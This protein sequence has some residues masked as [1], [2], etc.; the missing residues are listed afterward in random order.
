MNRRYFMAVLAATWAVPSPAADVIPAHL[1]GIWATKNSVMRGTALF[2]GMALYLGA[3]GRGGIVGGPPPIG[4]QIAAVFN[5]ASNQLTF[6]MIEGRKVVGRGSLDYDP[7]TQSIVSKETKPQ[8]LYRR[9]NEL[10]DE[11]RRFLGL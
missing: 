9:F 1:V 11:T 8:V 3:D 6:E 10:S 7:A 5:Q 2:E 4:V